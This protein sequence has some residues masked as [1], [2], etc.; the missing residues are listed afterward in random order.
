MA[1]VSLRNRFWMISLV[2]VLSA[3]F[4]VFFVLSFVLTPPVIHKLVT[5]DEEKRLHELA[6]SGRWESAGV[7]VVGVDGVRPGLIAVPLDDGRYLVSER[8]FNAW[9]A[10][11]VVQP[12]R[13]RGLLALAVWIGLLYL[14][15]T[16]LSHFVNKPIKELV[17]GVRA[18][19]AGKRDVQV[20]VP[21]EAE[22]AELAHG[23]NQMTRQLALREEELE[24]ALLAKERMFASTSHELRTPLTVILGYCQ[25]LEEGMKGEMTEQ[26]RASLEVIHRNAEGLLDQVEMLLTNSKLRT[27]TLPLE[28][29]SIDLRE[30]VEKL[31][32]DL[33]PL[34]EEK[35]LELKLQLPEQPALVEVDAKLAVQIARNLV[36]NA[37]KF[38]PQGRVE[39][40][41]SEDEGVVSFCVRDTGPGVQVAFEE[42]LF[43]E[44]SR[45]P[46]SEGVEGTGLGLALSQRLARAMNGEVLLAE[47]GPDGAVFCW[48]TPV[49]CES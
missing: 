14:L 43:Q 23:F 4:L 16:I 18:L 6:R 20:A 35:S 33:R 25:M 29:E 28:L 40:S 19:G 24:Q 39:V 32:E 47:N 11:K 48:R 44:F 3:F 13:G 12:P 5:L 49:Q 1:Q 37:L 34:A 2:F 26:Q 36:V 45:G 15:S 31:M 17:V 8:P 30:L 21:E 41:L 10:L 7:N 46:N 9:E 22:L 42:R 27:G 38:T